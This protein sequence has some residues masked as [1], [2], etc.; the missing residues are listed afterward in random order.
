VEDVLTKFLD[1]GGGIL[2]LCCNFDKRYFGHKVN[3]NSK[4][5]GDFILR[6]SS[7]YCLVFSFYE[8]YE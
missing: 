3:R 4:E 8:L 6:L 5:V 7:R 2:S 1:A